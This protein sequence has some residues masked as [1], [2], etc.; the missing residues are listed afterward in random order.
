MGMLQTS[1]HPI[2]TKNRCPLMGNFFQFHQFVIG[3]DTSGKA[4]HNLLQGIS[5]QQ[6]PAMDASMNNNVLD[7]LFCDDEHG[8][9]HIPGGFGQDLGARNI[10][11]GR[12]H[13]IPGYNKYREYCK[14][15]KIQNLTED[16]RP[17]NINAE[18]WKNILRAYQGDNVDD[19]DLFVGGLAETSLPRALVG[20]T[21]A[22]ILGE[23]FQKLK[24]G[25]RFFF[26][27]RSNF[28]ADWTKGLPPNLK[29]FVRDR[30]LGVI[31]CQHT[32][33]ATV[34]AEVMLLGGE[35]RACPSIAT[36]MD[37]L[38]RD[39]LESTCIEER[40]AYIGGPDNDIGDIGDID[41]SLA[42]ACTCRKNAECKFFTWHA[43]ENL[44]ILKNTDEGRRPHSN[45]FSGRADCCVEDLLTEAVTGQC[46]VD[47]RD[48]LL[49]EYTLF[50]KTLT[51]D[52]CIE[53]CLTKEFNYA[54]VQSSDECWCGNTAP[55]SSKI[56]A[57][58][59]CNEKCTGD[60]EQFCG[61][62][63]R[64]NVFDTKIFLQNKTF[65]ENCPDGWMLFEGKCYGH[66]KDR[67][68]N[69]TD[70]ESFCQSWSTGSHLASIH[71]AEEQKFVQTTFPQHMWLGGSDKAKDG[72]WVW[73]DGTP[74]DYSDWSSGQPDNHGGDCLKG[75]WHN[76]LWDDDAC[77]KE[78]LFLC[79]K[80]F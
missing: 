10:Q 45:S 63:W 65:Q 28:G 42:C 27:L 31:L 13:G 69:W 47:D 11:R 70:A 19:I 6:S 68:L 66:P 34:P 16:G 73:S 80:K 60:S 35:E 74:W 25:D 2:R 36:Q 20:E 15:E 39:L 54:G 41:S 4:W 75:N 57:Q 22:C 12:D 59:E 14:L 46:F 8:Q 71:S 61:G 64:M 37:R 50:K 7:F 1:Q 79:M 55:P 56:V 52:L 5:S 40:I 72:T 30:S 77:S 51:P 53:H 32:D 78:Y 44:C 21:F 49:E 62:S 3:D 9:C 76:L 23:Q 58:T 17:K 67:K 38:R 18:N 48:R 33:M 29:K 26:T 24:E 43:H